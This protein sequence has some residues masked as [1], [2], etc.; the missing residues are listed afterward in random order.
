MKLDKEQVD[1]MD[2]KEVD[3]QLRL[4]AKTYKLDEPIK[5]WVTPELSD[6]LD[7][8]I[9]TLA[10]LEDRKQWIEQYKRPTSDEVKE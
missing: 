10:Y 1:L 8:I 3:K 5:E 4:L 9:N 6:K 7:D 2:I